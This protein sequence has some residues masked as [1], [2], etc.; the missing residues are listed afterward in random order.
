MN[1]G[2]DITSAI[3]DLPYSGLIPVILVL[4]I[5][6]LLWLAGRKVLRLAF[7]SIGL[8]LGGALGWTIAAG[9]DLSINPWV[10]A[11]AGGIILAVI[12]V[13]AYRF[14]V[15][16]LMALALGIAC[17]L[18]LYTVAQIGGVKFESA[19]GE[20]DKAEELADAA[21]EKLE[22]LK[23]DAKEKLEE[24][25]EKLD[26]M[27][28]AKEKIGEELMEQAASMKDKIQE[29]APKLDEQ[30]QAKVDEARH[31]AQELLDAGKAKWD[32][33]PPRLR[34]S[35]MFSAAI[36]AVLGLLIAAFAASFSATVVTSLAGSLLVLGS[37]WVTATRLGV[38]EGPWLPSTP[39]A[40]LVFWA[41]LWVIG[42]G[43]QWTFRRRPADKPA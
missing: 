2:N 35:M 32:G 21:S 29:K 34:T 27:T 12:L 5:G 16:G 40:W 42:L 13:I 10:A 7:A 41:V 36:G 24:A 4:V 26:D 11:L 20:R 22:D 1:A 6:L 33:A 8:L 38:P 9:F 28:A 30:T 23:D 17:P 19:P 43:V 15:A 14:A 39:A 25:K 31:A 3:S 18:A 37:G